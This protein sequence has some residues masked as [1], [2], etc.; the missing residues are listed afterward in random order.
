MATHEFWA[1][2]ISLTDES[3]I[4]RG[5]IA[6]PKQITDIYLLALAFTKGGRVVT[7]D[8]SMAWQAIKGAGKDVLVV[9]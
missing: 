4:A 5:A 3:L 1:D 2:S 6:G 8:Q 9:L 7:F